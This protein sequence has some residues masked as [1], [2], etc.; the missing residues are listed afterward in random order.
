MERRAGWKRI[1]KSAALERL[2]V[3]REKISRAKQ[4]HGP[5]LGL[6]HGGR[7]GPCMPSTRAGDGI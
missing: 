4:E 3:V 2:L 5:A 1:E 6:G 7:R